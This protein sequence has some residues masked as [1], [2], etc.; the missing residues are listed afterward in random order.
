[1]RKLVK[2]DL[3]TKLIIYKHMNVDILLKALDNDSNEQIM[4]LNSIKINQLK[5]EVLKELELD[6]EVLKKYISKLKLYRY[7]D[8]LNDLKIGAYIRWINLNDPETIYLNQG[9]IIC[10]ILVTD[11]GVS[12]LCKN[13]VN[14]HFQIKT[15]EQHIFQKL[16]QQEQVLLAAIDHLCK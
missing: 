8:E 10:D 15:D 1:M 9:A 4:N 16:S 12:I 7:I 3:N 2:V 11:T 14:K 6:K 13:F 5:L